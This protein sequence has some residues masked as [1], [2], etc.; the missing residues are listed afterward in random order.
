MDYMGYT[1]PMN[2]HTVG[3]LF[4]GV[5][6]A[7]GLKP[8]EVSLAMGE[9][10]GKSVSVATVYKIE[11]GRMKPGL[12]RLLALLHVLRVDP[13]HVIELTRGNE[14]A[15]EAERIGR[16]LAMNDAEWVASRTDE[17]AQRAAEY[18]SKHT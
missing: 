15:T 6:L 3:A 2:A 13:S 17:Q 11:G 14:D 9:V 5:R 18:L 7:R 16:E 10:L 1:M 12:E 4:R 8:E